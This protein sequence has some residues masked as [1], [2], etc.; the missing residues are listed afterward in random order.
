MPL[1][2]NWGEF[3]SPTG[4]AGTGNGTVANIASANGTVV[5]TNPTGPNTNLEVNT[6][7][8]IQGP[9]TGD[10]ITPIGSPLASAATIQN[11]A[12]VQAVIALNAVTSLTGDV[13]TSGEGAAAATVV[14]VQGVA[15]TAA[16]ATLVSQLNGAT[17][18]ATTA[19]TI[20]PTA[21]EQTILT[22]STT[23]T[24]FQLPASTAQ[25]SS[26]NLVVN[27]ST[28]N[29]LVTPG[30]STTIVNVAGVSTAFGANL[31]L[32]A[33][34]M[35]EFYL[36]GSVWYMTRVVPAPPQV[37]TA[38]GT[39]APSG[40]GNSIFAVLTV[41]GGAGGANGNASTGGY[42]GGGGEVL[43]D[44]YLGNVTANQTITIG[45]GGAAGANGSNTSIG[46]L[47]TADFGYAASAQSGDFSG[48]S[49]TTNASAG[50]GAGGQG[51]TTSTTGAIGGPGHSRYGPGGGGGGGPTSAT[52]GHGGSSIGGT[53]GGGA[54][55]GGGGGGGGSG[56]NGNAGGA[57]T[58]GNGGNGGTN[59]GGGGGGGGVGT[60]GG[61][62]GIGGSG[63]VIIYQVA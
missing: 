59:T 21:G 57:N 30:T 50:S 20:T 54:A 9:L 47:V 43:I 23:G 44:W 31:N 56:L 5:V 33:G 49:I 63:Y 8:F 16:E 6:N 45:G 32:N 48:I 10:V 39:W 22:G 36:I 46:S 2:L 61:T 29:V 25:V 41:G 1:G 60:A 19:G 13:T 34:A 40:T 15:V 27:N 28:V 37:F 26:P 35:M 42:G 3:G 24:T 58:G 18:R 51:T 4:E 38:N 62:G 55:L 17:T 7:D 12:S 53:G 14:R 52:G 11:T